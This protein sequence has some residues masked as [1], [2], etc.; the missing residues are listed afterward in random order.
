VRRVIY[1]LP[2][3]VFAGCV[4]GF[5]GSNIQIDL[6]PGTPVQ[7]SQGQTP[8]ARELPANVHFR[9]FAIDQLDDRDVLF[10]IQRFEIHKIVDLNSPCFIDLGDNV[11][12]PGIHVSEFGRAVARDTGI[13]DISMPPP[14]ATEQQ[15][16][17]A[18]TAV[19]RMSNVAALGG[20]NAIKVVSSASEITYPAV[21]ADCDGSGLP[22]PACTD[23]DDN[24][25]RLAICQATWK[26]NPT[27]FEGTDRILTAPLNGTTFGMV[28]GVN[29]VFPAPVGGAQFFVDEALATIDEYAISIHTDGVDDAGTLFLTGLPT[30]GP[31]GVR[32]V[33]MESPLLPGLIT[34]ELAIFADLGEDDVHF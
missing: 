10:E 11:R 18:A 32:H 16:I 23:E 31:R 30:D 4:D 25:R 3:I 6:S 17:D 21:D 9:I 8:G 14:G 27:L 28:V 7:A 22:P 12:F 2:A 26:A 5:R 15:K 20:T 19:Q 33:H 24:A 13:D 29:P 34:A 1:I